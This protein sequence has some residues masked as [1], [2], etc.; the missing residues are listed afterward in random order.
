MFAK[1][2][3]NERKQLISLLLGLSLAFD[4]VKI[5]ILNYKI[6]LVVHGTHGNHKNVACPG[7]RQQTP[8][9]HALPQP[10]S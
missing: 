4:S 6:I 2:I 10:C 9:Q 5:K 3:S 1:L 7:C 8:A